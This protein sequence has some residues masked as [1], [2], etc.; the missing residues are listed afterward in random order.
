MEMNDRARVLRESGMGLHEVAAVLGIDPA[1]VVLG[2]RD[3]SATIGPEQE[4]LRWWGPW[5]D[6]VAYP[7]GA[8]VTFGGDLYACVNPVDPDAAAGD[9]SADV[10]S[11]E[12]M[13]G[14]AVEGWHIIG[15]PG[16]PAFENGWHAT[17]IDSIVRFRRDPAGKVRLEGNITGGDDPFLSA[18][19]LPNGYRPADQLSLPVAADGAVTTVTITAGGAVTPA[20]QFS[21]PDLS[22]VEFY[23][24]PGDAPS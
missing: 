17:P 8:V 15:A 12:R 4:A 11:W 18:F 7:R 19:T 20:D 14:G 10:N 22:A 24:E 13:T 5:S 6:T 1:D 23:A 16:E 3:P 9:P 21:T 2:E